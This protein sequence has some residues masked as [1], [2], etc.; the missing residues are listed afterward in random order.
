M[1][2]DWPTVIPELAPKGP[3]F[4]E[5][6]EIMFLPDIPF[7]IYHIVVCL[8]RSRQQTL[9]EKESFVKYQ[10]DENLQ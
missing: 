4:V 2:L 9:L 6:I 7:K 1:L 8:Y 10:E 3:R 5:I